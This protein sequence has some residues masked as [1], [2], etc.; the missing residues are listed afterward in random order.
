MRIGG[1]TCGL[2]PAQGWFYLRMDNSLIT[3]RKTV[4]QV[5]RSGSFSKTA[6]ITYGL[7]QMTDYR[8]ANMENG[9]ALPPSKDFHPIRSWPFVRINKKIYGSELS[10][11]DS[12]GL[13]PASLPPTPPSKDYS[14]TRYLKFWKMT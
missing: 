4:W 2:E 11:A 7:E 5:I 10:V 12:T 1:R 9:F 6:T 8:D 3:P 13:T 14:A